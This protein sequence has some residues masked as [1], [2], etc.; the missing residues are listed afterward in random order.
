MTRV[1]LEKHLGNRVKITVFDGTV[2]EGFLHKT[3]EESFKN[4]ANLYIPHNYYF[5]AARCSQKP[6]TCL[7]KVSHIKKFKDLEE[8]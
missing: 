6:I 2:I 3:G 1:E 8:K 5:C 7:F 4:V